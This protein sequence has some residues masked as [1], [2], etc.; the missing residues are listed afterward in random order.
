MDASVE[1]TPVNQGNPSNTTHADLEMESTVY[2]VSESRACTEEDLAFPDI[3]S[4]F[5]ILVGVALVFEN[6]L[7]IYVIG[8]TRS[9]HSIT[10]ILVASMGITDVLVGAQC[11]IMGLISLPNGLRS[12][13][14]FS[15]SDVHVFDSVMISLSTSLVSV[16]IL[17][18]SLLAVDR[19]LFILWPFHYTRRVTRSRVLLTAGG[20]WMLGLGYVLFLTI[21][22]Q[23][24]KYRTICIISHTPVAYTYWP[25][26]V[27]YFLCLIVVLAST[28]GIT[29]IAL[30]H[31]RR[32]KM[33]RLAQAT[34][35]N[36]RS[37]TNKDSV[38]EFYHNSRRGNDKATVNV[39][40]ENG[41]LCGVYQNK[42]PVKTS[43]VSM[44]LESSLN[45]V[46]TDL[47]FSSFVRSEYGA[48]FDIVQCGDCSIHRDFVK[49]ETLANVCEETNVQNISPQANIACYTEGFDAAITIEP[50]HPKKI[51]NEN[52][53]GK[54]FIQTI[55]GVRNAHRMSELSPIEPNNNNNKE[56]GG[57]FQKKN[58]KIIKF[59]TVIF[60]S[61]FICTFPFML[62][63]LIV[64]IMDIPLISDNKT[65]LLQFPIV[66][67][68]GMN[69]LIITH[70]NKDFRAALAQR[71]SCRRVFV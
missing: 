16:S 9:L 65:E 42:D 69:F 39:Q 7:L 21:Q 12:W 47:Q 25:F 60:G 5:I 13:L 55:T 19:Y 14:N 54:N 31:R 30:N 41:G 45:K 64:K 26:I 63:I 50:H 49:T 36:R 46:A 56:S 38:N 1:Q 24:E 17:H 52:G 10:N 29:K 43:I 8:R 70:M 15:P 6:L 28:F 53:S 4:Y 34:A 57:L 18:V 27:T 11:S 44:I 32:G 22:F 23:N 67:N 40:N 33:R 51:R 2:G 3:L 66:L 37:D 68:S 62:L 58:M 61:F 35:M 71:L 48:M 20:I 59:I